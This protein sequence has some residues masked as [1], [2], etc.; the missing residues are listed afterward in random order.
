VVQALVERFAALGQPERV[1]RC[2][3]HLDLASLDL[4]Q[5]RAQLFLA[6]VPLARR[7]AGSGRDGRGLCVLRR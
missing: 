4:D 1:E 7:A 3:L 6:V 5:A 2:V